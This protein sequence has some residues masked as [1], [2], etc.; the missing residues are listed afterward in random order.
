[1]LPLTQ[2]VSKIT[3]KIAITV[4]EPQEFKNKSLLFE[5]VECI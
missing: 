5:K 2:E 4:Y 3:W 1:M